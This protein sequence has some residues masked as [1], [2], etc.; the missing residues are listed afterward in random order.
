[1]ALA[2]P[3]CCD[4]LVLL[5]TRLRRHTAWPNGVEHQRNSLDDQPMANS[6]A[7]FCNSH[8]QYDRS[9]LALHFTQTPHMMSLKGCPRHDLRPSG[10]ADHRVAGPIQ[11]GSAAPQLSL[12]A[13]LNRC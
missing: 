13:G 5:L 6:A 1:M 11:V 10:E 12:G 4:V 7:T 8:I 3:F 9:Q 2:S